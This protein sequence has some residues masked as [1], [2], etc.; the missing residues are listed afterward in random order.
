VP[1]SDEI[2]EKEMKKYDAQVASGADTMVTA[3]KIDQTLFYKEGLAHSL[4]FASRLPL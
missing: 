4:K 2:W 3:T 1:K